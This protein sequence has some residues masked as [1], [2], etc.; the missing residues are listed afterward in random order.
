MET[1]QKTVHKFLFLLVIMFVSAWQS[2]IAQDLYV[3]NAKFLK[4]QK[5]IKLAS[6]N[7]SYTTLEGKSASTQSRD[8]FYGAKSKLSVRTTGLS[9]ELLQKI[10]DEAY[11]DFVAKLEAKG[12]KVTFFDA[13]ALA[14]D[15]IKDQIVKNKGRQGEDLSHYQP[16]S[17]LKDI[18]VAATGMPLIS[19]LD[20]WLVGYVAKKQKE[21][22]ITVNY[23][24]NSGYLEANASKRDDKFFGKI[25][26]K[27]K[28]KFHPG[29]QV[30]W[31]SGV[32]IWVKKNKSGAIKIN[33]HIFSSGPAGTLV[34]DDQTKLIS[35]SSAK[36]TLKI[37]PEK[38]HADAIDVLKQANT[39]IVN[40]MAESI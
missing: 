12:L 11:E 18:T 31:R 4:G 16:F 26:N 19:A 38:Y 13:E 28:V 10:T 33:E 2:V 37:D 25:Y 39:K 9:P 6:F 34:I 32:D 8:N 27:T 15:Y 30:F 23:L 24:I 36:M 17:Y 22:P 20:S 14:D 5:E 21:T 3:K 29:V 35:Y 7:V 40:K 1:Y